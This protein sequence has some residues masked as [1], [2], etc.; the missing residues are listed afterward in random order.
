LG[1]SKQREPS[2][3]PLPVDPITLLPHDD[4]IPF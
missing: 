1:N 3:S 2:W 4:D